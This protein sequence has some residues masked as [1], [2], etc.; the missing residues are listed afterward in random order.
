MNSI[1]LA[2]G[3]K[4]KRIHLDKA[5]VEIEG[6]KFIEII[7][8]KIKPIFENIFIVSIS[9]EKFKNYEDEKVKLLKDDFKCGP[10]GGIY[11]GITNSKS[12]FNFILAC[13]MPF[14]N[15][16]LI[17][18]MINL[19]KDYDILVPIVNKRYQVLHSIYGKNVIP[20]L[21]ENIILKKYKLSEVIKRVKTKFITQEEIEK[22]CEPYISFFNLNTKDDLNFIFSNF[23]KLNEKHQ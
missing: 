8:Q 5:F 16:E 19:Q 7:I 13:D 20:V 22:I 2:K 9:P 1:I 17:K 4:S 12:T 6:K 14:I 11:T 15:V 10:I 3:E 21:E 23:N 18:Y